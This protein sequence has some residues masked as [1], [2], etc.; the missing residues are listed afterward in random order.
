[1]YNV[2]SLV[3]TDIAKVLREEFDT[4]D[5]AS[6][7]VRQPSKFPHVSIVESDNYMLME[8]LD[9][10]DKERYS[11]VMYEVNVYSNK[12][13]GKKAECRKIM[14]IID[15]MMY[16]MNFIRT[17]LT[18]VPN[19]EDATIYRMTA[20]YQAVTNGTTMFRI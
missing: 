19:M 12:T 17:A 4:I 3:L 8:A 7:Y 16:D 1:M 9:S 10:S 18:P 15:N 11:A 5:I 2:E 14:G 20:R 6:E 13:S